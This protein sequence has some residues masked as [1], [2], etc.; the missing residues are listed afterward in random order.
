MDLKDREICCRRASLENL[1]EL[2]RKTGGEREN[3]ERGTDRD[4]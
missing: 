4:I 1:K 3:E 2:S